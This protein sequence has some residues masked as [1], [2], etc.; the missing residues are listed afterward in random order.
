MSKVNYMVVCA[1][2]IRNNR[3]ED[4]IGWK[5]YCM[6]EVID[7]NGRGNEKIRL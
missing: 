2:I 6:N 1:E 4:L 3:V 7:A 5:E